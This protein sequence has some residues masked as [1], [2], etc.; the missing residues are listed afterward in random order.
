VRRLIIAIII[1]L[2]LITPAFAQEEA[3]PEP[4]QSLDSPIPSDVLP[5]L[6]NART[7]L[8][9]LVTSQIGG[10]RPVGWSG[11]L[12]ITDPQLALLIRLDLEVLAG[13]L[14]SADQRPIGWFG[15]VS[16]TPIAIARDIR[17]DLELLA[18]Q[19]VQPGVRPPGWAGDT[20][21]MRCD[22]STQ[23]LV[24]LLEITAQFVVTADPGNVDYC[25]QVAIQASQFTEA[26]ILSP[27][28]STLIGGAVAPAG[29]ITANGNITIAFLDRNAR[30]SVGVVPI[31]EPLVPVA[32]SYA[33]F[34][35]MVLVR[36]EDF[37]VFV[38]FTTTTLTRAQFEALG[39]VNS[40]TPSPVCNAYWCKV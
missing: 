33:Q 36:G 17:H 25:Q 19:V 38:D 27:T 10:E 2:V 5:I 13:Q 34:S 1:G 6:I 26:R 18:D 28:S 40:L 37:E 11:S 35:N 3:T 7:D 23:N 31:G 16:S 12:D 29:S 15:A 20:P 24:Q 9:I 21:I 22:R 8:E 4:D 14:L 39:D 30:Q 32:R